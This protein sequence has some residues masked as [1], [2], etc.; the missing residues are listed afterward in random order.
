[1]KHTYTINDGLR[2]VGHLLLHRPCTY[3]LAYT[4]RGYV[5]SPHDPNANAFCY[6][7]ALSVVSDK[8]HLNEKILRSAATGKTKCS[9]ARDWDQATP[10]RRS[11][12]SQALASVTEP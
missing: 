1:M 12:I 7:G 11:E 9:M 3:A 10:L 8:L 6:M 5:T 2:T 4:K